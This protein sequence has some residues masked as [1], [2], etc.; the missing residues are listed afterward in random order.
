VTICFINNL[1]ANVNNTQKIYI[2]MLCIKMD[3][4]LLVSTFMLKTLCKLKILK[5]L[6]NL[7]KYFL[8]KKFIHLA[9]ECQIC[10]STMVVT[11]WQWIDYDQIKR[12][13]FATHGKVDRGNKNVI[14]I[15]L[16]LNWGVIFTLGTLKIWLLLVMYKNLLSHLSSNALHNVLL[17]VK[18]D[19]HIGIFL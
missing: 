8:I 1:K 19:L 5:K 15:R 4:K 3:E 14:H 18:Q 11:Y 2:W 6:Y 16:G 9:Q 7:P 12:V 17:L 10:W 13:S